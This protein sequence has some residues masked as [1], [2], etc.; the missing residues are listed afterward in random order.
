MILVGAAAAD[1][2]RLTEGLRLSIQNLG[3]H[4]H[5]KPVQITVSCGVAE[6]RTGDLPEDV[7]QRADKA[8][9]KAKEQGRNCCVAG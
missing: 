1:A 9:Y 6:F 3:F 4:Y 7:F 2:L 8:L 5:G